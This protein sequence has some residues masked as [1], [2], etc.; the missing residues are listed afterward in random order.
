MSSVS[1]PPHPRPTFSHAGIPSR[2]EP[3][4][5]PAVF[6]QALATAA[7]LHDAPRLRWLAASPAAETLPPTRALGRVLTSALAAAVAASS[8]AAL[9]ALLA[10]PAAGSLSTAALEALLP[11]AAAAAAADAPTPPSASPSAYPITGGA[12]AALELLLIRLERSLWR[13]QSSDGGADA[14]LTAPRRFVSLLKLAGAAGSARLAALI[15]RH[16][17]ADHP[18]AAALVRASRA[19]FVWRG[20]GAGSGPATLS[21]L[22][23]HSLDAAGGVEGEWRAARPTVQSWG[24]MGE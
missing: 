24:P 17:G 9:A 11:A 16:G 20:E 1:T 8:P 12:H 13:P 2:M 22:L 3:P 5:D 23:L 10:M 19:R 21:Q 4:L 7:A 15:W 14:A 18:P 6:V